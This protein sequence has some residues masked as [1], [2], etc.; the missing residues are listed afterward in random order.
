M[1]VDLIAM[2][3]QI[4]C[5]QYLGCCPGGFQIGNMMFNA[6]N[7]IANFT[8]FM[9]GQYGGVD[10]NPNQDWDAVAAGKCCE[11]VQKRV[12]MDKCSD[13]GIF[14]A[15]APAPE[16]NDIIVGLLKVGAACK[17]NECEGTAVCSPQTNVCVA[18][19]AQGQSCA[20]MPCE[21]GLYCDG[22]TTCQPRKADGAACGGNSECAS[23]ACNANQCA[24]GAPYTSSC[25]P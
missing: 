5:P 22:A 17:T 13:P 6:A 19:A 16:C 4:L 18:T 2:A 11:A 24:P 15:S 23:G 1:P 20:A 14:G 12:D 8:Q 3:P 7:C 10:A 9:Q 21:Q 25:T